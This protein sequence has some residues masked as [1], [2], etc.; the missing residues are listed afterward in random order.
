MINLG[1]YSYLTFILIA[2]IHLL[3]I[4]LLLTH[5]YL[6][7]FVSV[8]RSACGVF[9]VKAIEAVVFGGDVTT[10]TYEKLFRY[11]ELI[12]SDLIKESWSFI[13]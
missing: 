11:R 5:P 4:Y 3:S 6:S 12:C 1:L 13:I 8:R 2:D 10:I 9:T 7:V